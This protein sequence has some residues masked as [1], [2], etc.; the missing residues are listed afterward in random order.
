M[1]APSCHRPACC[2]CVR[3]HACGGHRT[4]GCRSHATGLKHVL[5]REDA[6]TIVDE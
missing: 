3:V 4:A 2:R 5:I 6:A 1:R